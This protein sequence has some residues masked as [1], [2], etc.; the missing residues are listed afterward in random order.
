[1][2][3]EVAGVVIARLDRLRQGDGANPPG[4]SL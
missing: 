4:V 3:A 1:M 2:C